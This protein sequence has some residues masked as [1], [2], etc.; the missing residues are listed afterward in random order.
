MAMEIVA[1]SG[2]GDNIDAVNDVLEDSLAESEVLVQISQL[3]SVSNPSSLLQ[4]SCGVWGLVD[5]P[6]D[7][8]LWDHVNHGDLRWILTVQG[9][10]GEVDRANEAIKGP[11][12]LPSVLH[13]REF[14]F[15][16]FISDCV[17][18]GS[19]KN[20]RR[21][22]KIFKQF[23]VPE[24]L[25]KAQGLSEPVMVSLR[26]GGGSPPHYLDITTV[27]HQ[28]RRRPF[29]EDSSIKHA[30]RCQGMGGVC[31]SSFKHFGRRVHS[32]S[33]T[34]I[35]A[36]NSS[37]S[38][39][40]SSEWNGTSQISALGA[41]SGP[42]LDAASNRGESSCQFGHYLNQPFLTKP[43]KLST[44]AHG[45]PKAPESRLLGST[46]IFSLNYQVSPPSQPHT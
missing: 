30:V 26:S 44:L 38:L 13:S 15:A 11:T 6:L 35:P 17:R 37:G 20:R 2:S 16:R 46:F 9:I 22:W 8:T 45:D 31:I 3:V 14:P 12:A 25:V 23:I 10:Q 28:T 27:P 1:I 33:E 43:F 7:K 41:I 42:D 40:F 39:V 21:L 36:V 32:T 24:V 19:R 18:S 4:L 29:S 34:V 5:P